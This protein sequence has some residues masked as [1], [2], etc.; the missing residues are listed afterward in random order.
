MNKW[1]NAAQA[2]LKNAEQLADDAE[3]LGMDHAG[4][5]FALAVI[6]QEEAAKAFLFH[7]ISQDAVPVSPLV[8]RIARDHACKH[9]LG[10]IMDYMHPEDFLGNIAAVF[11]DRAAD[12]FRSDIADALNILRHEKVGRWESKNWFWDEEPEYDATAKRAADGHFDREK[13]NGLYVR[14]GSD[15]S[16]A[17]TPDL[18]RPEAAKEA[19]ERARRFGRLVMQLLED[20]TGGLLDYDRIKAAFTALFETLKVASHTI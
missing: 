13:Q 2:S 16:I 1:K 12:R 9:L 11:E 10:M 14:I 20:D 8:L 19:I 17:S 6:A 7:L 18:V 5:S 15:G 3:W 4:S